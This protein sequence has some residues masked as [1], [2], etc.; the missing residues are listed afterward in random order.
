MYNNGKTMFMVSSGTYDDYNF[1]V[2][3][4]DIPQHHKP[5]KRRREADEIICLR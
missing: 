3:R 5:D 2:Q 4:R 1:T